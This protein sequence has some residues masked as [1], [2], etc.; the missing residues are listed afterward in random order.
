ME[1]FESGFDGV[2]AV[3]NHPRN[4]ASGCV[5]AIVSRGWMRKFVDVTPWFESFPMKLRYFVLWITS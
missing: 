2:M 5:P 1:T 4:I 3:V